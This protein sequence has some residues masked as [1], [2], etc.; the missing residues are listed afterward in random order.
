MATKKPAGVIGKVLHSG[1]T[2]DGHDIFV[3][4][5]PEVKNKVGRVAN[6]SSRVTIQVPATGYISIGFPHWISDGNTGTTN[7]GGTPLINEAKI[8]KVHTY[9]RNVWEELTGEKI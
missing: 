4:E 8:G 2:K 7:K 1:K 9:G 6:G 5:A 3:V